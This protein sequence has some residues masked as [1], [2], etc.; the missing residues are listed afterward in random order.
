MAILWRLGAVM[1]T[2]SLRRSAAIEHEVRNTARTG[3]IEEKTNSIHQAS[4]GSAKREA[5]VARNPEVFGCAGARS[6]KVQE[7]PL[8]RAIS[9]CEQEVRGPAQHALMEPGACQP[10][11]K[12]LCASTAANSRL[13]LLTKALPNPSIKP[14]PNGKPP[15]QRYSA[16]LHFLQRWPGVWPLVPAYVE[17]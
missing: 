16:V 4:S 5:V 13:G 15:G 3:C 14:S 2:A 17:R 7:S 9:A 11:N 8:R 6:S 1:E 12:S 10:L